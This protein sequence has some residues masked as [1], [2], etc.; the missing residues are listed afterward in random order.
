MKKKILTIISILAILCSAPAHAFDFT[1]VFGGKSSSGSGSDGGG[2]GALLNGLAGELLSTSDFELQD[3]VGTWKYAAPAV[4]LEGSNA[5]QNLGGAAA[6]SVIENKL[7]PYYEK[8]K[9]TNLQITINE[10]STFVMNTGL[11][12]AKGTLS[13]NPEEGLTFNFKAFMKINVGKV[14]AQASKLGNNELSLTFDVSKLQ[15]VVS[16]VAEIAN[17]DSFKQ[18]SGLLSSYEGVYAGFRLK[19]VS[20]EEPQSDQ[21]APQSEIPDADTN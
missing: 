5:L 17:N 12:N 8:A 20:A 2:L 15:N 1:K 4:S 11:C 14:K 3:I 6:T 19:R 10:D 9:L 18:L 13:Y 7:Q 21:A 16:K